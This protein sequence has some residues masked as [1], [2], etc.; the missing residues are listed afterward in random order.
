GVGGVRGYG[1]TAG[2][3]GVGSVVVK[4]EGGGASIA[5]PACV[6][7]DDTFLDGDVVAPDLEQLVVGFGTRLQMQALDGRSIAAEIDPVIGAEAGLMTGDDC[8]PDGGGHTGC[9]DEGAVGIDA[10]Q[11]Q[12]RLVDVEADGMTDTIASGFGV[13]AGRDEDGRSAARG[14]DRILDVLVAAVGAELVDQQVGRAVDDDLLDARQ[15]IGLAVV[16]YDP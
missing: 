11:R 7:V 13:G 15:L 3:I 14:V 16:G 10:L 4:I 5:R 9:G 6:N 2:L 1:V 8:R 12:V